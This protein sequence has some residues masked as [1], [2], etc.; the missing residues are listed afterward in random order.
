M[1]QRRN[2]YY[3]FFKATHYIVALLFVLLFFFHCNFRLSSWYASRSLPRRYL[4]LTTFAY[5][6]LLHCFGRSLF[7]L[8]LLLPAPDVPWP[9]TLPAS[10]DYEPR[11]RH[12]ENF[13]PSEQAQLE[14]GPAHVP[15]LPH[16]RSPRP[17]ISPIHHLQHPV[18]IEESARQRSY[19]LRCG[20]R[21]HY[22]PPCQLRSEAPGL[23]R[24][25]S[26]RRPLW[27]REQPSP[28]FLRP[29]SRRCV[30][31]WIRVLTTLH[32]VS[33]HHSKGNWGT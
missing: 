16:A 4:A 5:Q 9:R 22:R 14:V 11:G 19:V 2:A 8:T 33:A 13:H 10:S 7:L 3:E 32:H 26:T 12:D 6:G 31:V 21:G 29:K 18:H 24:P 28:Y 15:P 20:S 25:R 30:W 23:Q 1:T 17:D 27:G